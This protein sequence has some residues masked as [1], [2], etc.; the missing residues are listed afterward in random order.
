LPVAS[1]PSGGAS[2]NS[3]KCGTLGFTS[4]WLEPRHTILFLYLIYLIIT[5]RGVRVLP[6]EGRECIEDTVNVALK[7]FDKSN[8]YKDKEDQIPAICTSDFFSIQLF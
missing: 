7:E 5:P 8:S 6:T 3:T 4:P 2:D 1:P